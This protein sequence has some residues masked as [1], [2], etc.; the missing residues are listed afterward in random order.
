MSVIN[1]TFDYGF[2]TLSKSNK[3]KRY[4]IC[5][6]GNKYIDEALLYD[7]NTDIYIVANSISLL[8]LENNSCNNIISIIDNSKAKEF[9]E[10][11]V[12]G[13][14]LMKNYEKLHDF[15]YY[16]QQFIKL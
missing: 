6:Y 3:F 1:E 4:A 10:Y 5:L 9:S 14:Q 7:A 11:V 2:T 12:E 13:C 8:D 16:K 15:E